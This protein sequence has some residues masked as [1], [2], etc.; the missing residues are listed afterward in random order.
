M[1]AGISELDLKEQ[2][3][4]FVVRRFH[5]TCPECGPFFH[6]RPGHHDTIGEKQMTRR[7]PRGQR[8]RLR[9]ALPLDER[10][11]FDQT[12]AGKREPMDG[13]VERWLALQ[14]AK[15]AGK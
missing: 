3:V 2:N 4:H 1:V 15:R 8:K 5:S 7:F 9:K 6:D 13:E 12:M 10:K 11:L 14:N